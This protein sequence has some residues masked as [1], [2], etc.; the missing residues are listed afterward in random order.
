M[1][2]ECFAPVEEEN[3]LNVLC[4]AVR[5][6]EARFYPGTAGSSHHRLLTFRDDD[7]ATPDLG[8]FR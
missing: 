6:S 5:L 8:R 2:G 4:A 7:A 3:A 1:G